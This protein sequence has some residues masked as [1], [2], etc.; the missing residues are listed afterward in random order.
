MTFATKGGIMAR[1]HAK[2]IAL[3][4]GHRTKEEI[5]HRTAMEEQSKSGQPMSMPDFMKNNPVAVKEFKRVKNLY[6]IINHDDE[7]YSATI[8]RYAMMRAEEDDLIKMKA[9]FEKL[10]GSLDEKL[11]KQEIEFLSYME[12]SNG[13]KRDYM[14]SIDLLAKHRKMLLDLEKTSLLTLAENIRAIPKKEE[15]KEP[16]KLERYMSERKG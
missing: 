12:L 9:S 6:K 3:V 10:L 13:V 4:K 5:E 8:G 15:K 1:N 14:K 11:E 16:S 7:I 2:P